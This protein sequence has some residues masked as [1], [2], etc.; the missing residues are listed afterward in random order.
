LSHDHILVSSSLYSRPF[1]YD[2]VHMNSE[3]VDH[4]SDHEPQVAPIPKMVHTIIMPF[5]VVGGEP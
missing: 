3:F 2:V 5:I 1:A 4:A